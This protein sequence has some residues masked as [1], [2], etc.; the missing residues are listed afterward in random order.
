MLKNYLKI[1]FRNLRKQKAYSFI[2]ILGLSVGLVIFILVLTIFDFNLSFDSFHKNPDRIY[3]LIFE[4]V[5]SSGSSQRDAY[6]R[7]PLA[8]LLVQKFPGIES[9]TTERRYFRNVFRYQDKKFY[10]K[11]ILFA[12]TNFLKIFNYPVIAGDKESP[13]SRPNSVVLTE[14]TARK[15]FGDENPIG[16]M[17][18][19]DFKDAVLTVT[20][21]TKDCP[22]N[23]SNQF[24]VLVSLPLG[25]N[26]DWGITGS[27]Y[28][29]LKLKKGESAASLESKFPAFIDESVPALRD[30]KTKLFLLPLKDIHLRSMDINIGFI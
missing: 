19:T 18:T 25:Y 28:T 21:V 11:G 10:E 2:N 17:L 30:T 29:F 24:D 14:S 26:D 20:A 6:S 16:K 3:L 12:D 5:S 8:N 4:T 15:Y 7:L 27:T 23:S 22:P 13:L 9:A 1:F